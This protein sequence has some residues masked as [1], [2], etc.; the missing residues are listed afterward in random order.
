VPVPPIGPDGAAD[1]AAD[2]AADGAAD[3]AA[4]AAADGALDEPPAPQAARKA[5]VPP[6]PAAAR[7]PRRLTRVLFI[8]AMTWS[9]SCS[10]IVDSP[11]RAGRAG[12]LRC[13]PLPCPMRAVRGP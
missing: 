7:K 8:F 6:S 10:A 13:R 3:A 5:A 2:A 1:A 11:P 4:D 12:D 9:R